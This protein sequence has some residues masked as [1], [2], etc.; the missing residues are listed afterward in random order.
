MKKSKRKPGISPLMRTLAT[1]I[2]GALAKPLPK[3]VAEKTKHHLLDTIAAMVSGSRLLPGERAIGYVKGLG[4]K[5]EACV[6]G[7]RL[8]VTAEHAALATPDVIVEVMPVAVCHVASLPVTGLA[9]VARC[10]VVV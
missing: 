2:A 1:Y 5:P 3:A 9:S 7:S 6:I 10:V 4:G 8:V